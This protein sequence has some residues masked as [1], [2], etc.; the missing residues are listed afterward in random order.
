MS[1]GA[2]KAAL[3]PYVVALARELG[4]EG[5]TVNAVAPGLINDTPFFGEPMNDA[6]LRA[7]TAETATGRIDVPRD[8]SQTLRWLA[9]EDAGHIT[10]QVIQVNGGAQSSR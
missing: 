5:I 6:R 9:S 2:A 1:Y 8:V 4:P 10:A 3:H 7:H